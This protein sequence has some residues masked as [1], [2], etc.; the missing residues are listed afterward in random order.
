MI[1]FELHFQERDK[2]EYV[3]SLP[4]LQFQRITWKL[5]SFVHKS[6]NFDAV[7]WLDKDGI[8]SKLATSVV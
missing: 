6:E 3:L 5:C 4:V 8:S 7:R 1:G 2:I